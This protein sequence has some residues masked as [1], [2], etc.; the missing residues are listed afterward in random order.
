MVLKRKKTENRVIRAARRVSPSRQPI[1]APAAVATAT[2][3][4]ITTA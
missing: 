3:P 2:A 4:K 1:V